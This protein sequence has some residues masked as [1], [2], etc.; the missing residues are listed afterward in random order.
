MLMNLEIAPVAATIEDKV[1]IELVNDD[2]CPRY[3]GRVIK[4]INLDAETP[5]WMV[6]KTCV[7][8]EFVQLTL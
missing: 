7:A 4:G 6:R 3:L 1:S 5:L 8:V 2:A